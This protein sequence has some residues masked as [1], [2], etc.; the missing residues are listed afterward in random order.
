MRK[1]IHWSIWFAALAMAG[2]QAAFGQDEG[3]S[4]PP[5]APDDIPCQII[6]MDPKPGG[7]GGGGITNGERQEF[8]VEKFRMDLGAE[9]VPSEQMRLPELK[10]FEMD[11]AAM[12]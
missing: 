9:R 11:G 3:S 2:S 5:C 12:Q 7:G 6:R 8:D 4:E 1:L 10:Q